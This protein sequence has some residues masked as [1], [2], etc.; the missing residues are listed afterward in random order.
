MYARQAMPDNAMVQSRRR[1]KG[2]GTILLA[3]SL[4]D[5]KTAGKPPLFLS[6]QKHQHQY[7]RWT[8]MTIMT[9]AKP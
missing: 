3:E 7:H 9:V 2:F 8:T 5:K 6:H 1:E 4:T